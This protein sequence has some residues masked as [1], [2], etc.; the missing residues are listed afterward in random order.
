[1]TTLYLIILV[2]KSDRHVGWRTEANWLIMCTV[3]QNIYS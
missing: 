2:L 3:E 1:M